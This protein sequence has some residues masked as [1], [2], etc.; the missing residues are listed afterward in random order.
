MWWFYRMAEL[1]FKGISRPSKTRLAEE[2]CVN[3]LLARIIHEDFYCNC[4]YAAATSLEAGG[5]VA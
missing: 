4:R 3:T 1:P 5:L 2:E